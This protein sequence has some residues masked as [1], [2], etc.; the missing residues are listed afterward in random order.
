MLGQVP[1]ITASED[2]GA[3][4]RPRGWSELDTHQQASERLT[5]STAQLCIERW[6]SIRVVTRALTLT[7]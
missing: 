2:A 5:A 6:A 1:E 3:V 7:I 4:A